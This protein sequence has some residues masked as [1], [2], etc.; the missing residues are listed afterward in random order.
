[1]KKLFTYTR[2]LHTLFGNIAKGLQ[3]KEQHTVIGF[4]MGYYIYIFEK[5]L[6]PISVPCTYY[7]YSNPC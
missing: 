6:F 7:R 1:M 5:I 3:K 2:S 4:N